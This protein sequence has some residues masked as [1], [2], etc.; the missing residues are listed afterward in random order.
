MKLIFAKLIFVTF[1]F[2]SPLNADDL[3]E[4]KNNRNIETTLIS[5]SINSNSLLTPKPGKQSLPLVPAKNFENLNQKTDSYETNYDSTSLIYNYKKGI[6]YGLLG[7]NSRKGYHH[8]TTAA[9]AGNIDAI[10][11]LFWHIF[12]YL[13]TGNSEALST[14]KILKEI[15]DTN[16]LTLANYLQLL[17]MKIDFY[18]SYGNVNDFEEVKRLNLHLSPLDKFKAGFSAMFSIS[19]KSFAKTCLEE[20]AN[21][22]IPD[23]KYWLARIMLEDNSTV[24]SSN[25]LLTY[26][27]EAANSGHF[28]AIRT[29]ADIF[30]NGTGVK[31]N[32]ALAMH[33]YS[34]G[35]KFEDSHC[36]NMLGKIYQFGL[37]IVDVDLNMAEKYFKFTADSNNAIGCYNIGKLIQDEALSLK[38]LSKAIHL[39]LED[40]KIPYILKTLNNKGSREDYIKAYS[41]GST[42]DLTGNCRRAWKEISHKLNNNEIARAKRLSLKN[43]SDNLDW[44][45]CGGV[46]IVAEIGKYAQPAIL[47]FKVEEDNTV[48]GGYF[49]IKHKKFIRLYGQLEGSSVYLNEFYNEENTGRIVIDLANPYLSDWFHPKE[50][51]PEVFQIVNIEFL[52][53]AEFYQPAE[54]MSFEHPHTV[55][56]YDGSDNWITTDEV[57][58]Y[59]IGNLDFSTT[60]YL[61]M[62]VTKANAHLGGFSGLLEGKYWMSYKYEMNIPECLIRIELAPDAQYISV[63]EECRSCCGARAFLD[64]FYTISE[65][66]AL[67]LTDL[68]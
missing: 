66:H 56:M 14:L 57:D 64:G 50:D 33:F 6:E 20:A 1:L 68:N 39:G 40:A 65:L 16:N 23:A 59:R 49:Y 34:L 55:Y 42:L 7:P 2:H 46:E 47:R 58:L 4:I 3:I 11:A 53:Y 22:G 37:N 43:L 32:Y 30:Y 61:R 19:T 62:S 41:Y 28:L 63:T 31:S 21:A 36:H 54:L 13:W 51:T 26:L 15:P 5:K 17:E 67:N 44:D 48:T 27:F 60:A 12:E 52:D 9:K 8:L 10:D 24:L 35:A 25:L 45:M 29:L 18:E 38:Y